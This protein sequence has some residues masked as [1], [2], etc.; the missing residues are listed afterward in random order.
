MIVEFDDRRHASK[1]FCQQDSIYLRNRAGD[2]IEAVIY[3][4]PLG[5]RNVRQELA[6]Q[7]VNLL[8]LNADVR[9]ANLFGVADDQDLFPAIQHGQGAQIALARLVHDDHVEGAGLRLEGLDYPEERHDPDRDRAHRLDHRP[10]GRRQMALSVF[11]CPFTELPHRVGPGRQGHVL[12]VLDVG[13]LSL[14][15]SLGDELS[16]QLALRFPH[17]FEAILKALHALAVV[18]TNQP[19]IQSPPSPRQHPIL[20]Q[21]PDAGLCGLAF[22]L[23]RP[24]GRNIPKSL[25]QMIKPH[26]AWAEAREPRRFFIRLLVIFAGTSFDRGG[27]LRPERV[28]VLLFSLAAELLLELPQV[29]GQSMFVYRPHLPLQRLHVFTQAGAFV[30]GLF[31]GRAAQGGQ[32]GPDLSEVVVYPLHHAAE[33]F[34]PGLDV[35]QRHQR[36]GVSPRPVHVSDALLPSKLEF[37]EIVFVR[38]SRPQQIYSLERREFLSVDPDRVEELFRL[39]RKQEAREE[40]GRTLPFLDVHPQLFESGVAVEIRRQIGDGYLE[41]LN[42]LERREGAFVKLRA[43]LQEFAPERILTLSRHHQVEESQTPFGIEPLQI[44]ERGFEDGE[45]IDD[46]FRLRFA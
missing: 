34:Q 15:G 31:V 20:R 24:F 35:G 9:R 25:Q 42:L 41:S 46:L 2:L 36:L 14:P 21:R 1:V 18:K 10:V 26:Y 11:S 8:F 12:A 23:G 33:V 5:V 4:E 40:A 22:D 29:I 28:R 17:P 3:V 27:Q 19:L 30:K 6:V 13:D 38:E 7:L 32:G 39:L 45:R 43:G 37:S 16:D 44:G